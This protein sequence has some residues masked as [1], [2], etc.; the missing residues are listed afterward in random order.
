MEQRS[1]SLLL[2]WLLALSH[3]IKLCF[4]LTLNGFSQRSLTL[5]HFFAFIRLLR[6]VAVGHKQGP[7]CFISL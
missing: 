1:S 7:R 4:L 5:Y 6:E 3:H 2:V